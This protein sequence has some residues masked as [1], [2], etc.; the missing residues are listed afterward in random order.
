MIQII[1]NVP[2]RENNYP[3]IRLIQ[4]CVTNVSTCKINIIHC[5]N[6][7]EKGAEKINFCC[8]LSLNVNNAG[9]VLYDTHLCDKHGH[10]RS[11]VQTGMISPQER[12]QTL[13]FSFL[14]LLFVLITCEKFCFYYILG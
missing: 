4:A 13:P 9:V 8:F 12:E 10:S 2:N 7:C 14:F 3:T 1:W 6:W 5:V 11:C